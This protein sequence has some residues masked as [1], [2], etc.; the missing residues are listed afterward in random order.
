MHSTVDYVENTYKPSF[1]DFQRIKETL[2]SQ[3]L[4][5]PILLSN[6]FVSNQPYTPLLVRDFT[7]DVSDLSNTVMK[8]ILG[9]ENSQ[10]T[11]ALSA[12][13]SDAINPYFNK[14]K[15]FEYYQ[16]KYDSF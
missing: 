16:R 10:Y 11:A 8:I 9:D 14:R 4:P 6:G 2:F 15:T 3:L 7:R 5:S 13:S 12:L 1:Q